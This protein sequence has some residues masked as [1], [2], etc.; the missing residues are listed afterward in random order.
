MK[1]FLVSLA[2]ALAGCAP[3][4]RFVP[5]VEK[6]MPSVAAIYV[7]GVM[8][9]TELVFDENGFRLETATVPVRVEGAGV[10]ISPNNHVL[11]CSHLFWLKQ[12]TGITVCDVNET[13]TAG[14]LL[15]EDDEK[16]LGL[17]QTFFDTPTSYSRLADPRSLR[18]GQEVL[19]IGSPLGF[20]F[21][22]SHGIIS[23]LNRDNVG[24]NMTQSDAFL[25][26]GNSGGPLFNLRGEVVGINSRIIPPVNAPIFTGLGFS[27]QSGQIIE[28]LTKIRAK[29]AGMGLGLPKLDRGY[30]EGF[31]SAIGKNNP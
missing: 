23:A 27:V 15:A 8:E 24:Y 16:D 9:R 22:V 2:F 29:Y 11:T 14:E 21:S 25:N 6:A 13:C 20:P 18:V 1:G 10:F 12:I 3:I 30:W 17:V 7:T 26:P 19:A 28:F 4:E 5:V 31:L